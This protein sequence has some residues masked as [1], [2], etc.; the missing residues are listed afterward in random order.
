MITMFVYLHRTCISGKEFSVNENSRSHRYRAT[1]VTIIARVQTHTSARA[2]VPRL[3]LI[4]GVEPGPAR[5]LTL[6]AA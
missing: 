2:I 6:L 1:D 5:S 4:L 3:Q